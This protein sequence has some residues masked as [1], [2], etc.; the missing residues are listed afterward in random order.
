MSE[1]RHYIDFLD[2]AG[3]VA[4]KPPQE[5][6]NIEIENVFD[7]TGD[8]L[9][10][11]SFTW[12]DDVALKLTEYLE[13]G[14]TG[15]SNGILE[16]LPY[17]VTYE[18]DGTS[19]TVVNACINLASSE[20]E[21]DYC[22][23]VKA[24]IKETGNKDF[25]NTRADSF[26]FEYL[27]SL[28]STAAGYIS[29]SDYI[30][31]WYMDGAYPRKVEIIMGSITLF[32]I[33]KEVYETI[34]RIV[35][36]IAA[37]SGGATGAVETTLQL[38][39]LGVYLG[40]LIVGLVALINDIID[41]IFP[42]V[43]YHKG[44]YVRTL[45]QKACAYLGFGF[46]ST[47][48]SSGSLS[49]NQYILPP[50]NVEGAKVGNPSNEVGYF[51]GTFGDLL[52]ILIEQYNAEVTIIGNTLY[53]E[54]KGYFEN[55]STYRIPEVKSIR[56]YSTNA[57]DVS[58]NYVIEYLYDKVDLN[59]YDA[60]SGRIIQATHEP[61]TVYDKKNV[62]LKGLTQRTI[63]L[64]LPN[65]KTSVS[66][67][68]TRMT[69]IFNAIASLVSAVASITPWGGSGIPTIPSSINILNLDTHFISEHKTGI[70]LG[71]G[72]TDPSTVTALGARTLFDNYH[73]VEMIKPV[74]SAGA[75]NQWYRYKGTVPMCCA[76][77]LQ[78]TGNNYATYKGETAR[79][80]QCK[81]KV[82]DQVADIEFEVNKLWTSNLKL[83]LQ[84]PYQSN[85]I[86]T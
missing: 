82:Y 22:D 36:V 56:A 20:T 9:S 41:L 85:V 15:T 49:Y 7:G 34:K 73:Y 66:R 28:S 30:D 81:W 6:K 10:T 46:S 68:E 60:S 45:C 63:S 57:E 17:K 47:I 67:L 40:L 83:I 59:D 2:G 13:N 35:D 64:T 86:F 62:Q 78:I 76:D 74:Y 44:M 12:V 58:A 43:Y 1:V 32:L 42:F 23:I 37:T 11:G 50:K 3:F 80:I 14:I 4:V 27:T 84:E 21:F 65:V 53:L 25:L 69:D 61:I 75:G 8:R 26:R 18:C 51:E 54:R 19:Y 24:P 52:R 79:I 71:G 5:W 77:Y 70:Y 16:G 33:L 39:A 31:I 48:F 29:A 72:K 55:F 38:I